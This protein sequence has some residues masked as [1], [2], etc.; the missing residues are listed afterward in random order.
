MTPGGVGG[1]PQA[2]PLSPQLCPSGTL[3]ADSPPPVPFPLQ[4][5]PSFQLKKQAPLPFPHGANSFPAVRQAQDCRELGSGE[6][7]HGQGAPGWEPVWASL[8][9]LNR[10]AV[11]SNE[12]VNRS[13]IWKSRWL[14]PPM[15]TPG[16]HCMHE[17]SSPGQMEMHPRGQ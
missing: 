9:L 11:S 6:P 12:I 4:I 3:E 15:E 17:P 16:Y 7:E 8:K 13:T 14:A 1:G 2:L 10:D 5:T